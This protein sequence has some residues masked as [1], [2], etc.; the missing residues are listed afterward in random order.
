MDALLVV[1][2]RGQTEGTIPSAMPLTSL[3]E[4]LVLMT[5]DPFKMSCPFVDLMALK[6]TLKED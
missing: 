5:V 6:K 3:Q 2:R 1:D 4:A